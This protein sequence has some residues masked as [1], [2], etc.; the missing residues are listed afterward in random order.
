M[1]SIDVWSRKYECHVELRERVT[2]IIGDSGVGKTVFAAAVQNRANVYKIVISDTRYIITRLVGDSWYAVLR[3]DMD[4]HAYK[5]YV[6]D[7][8]DFMYT[9]EFARMYEQ[10]ENCYFI[11]ITRLELNRKTEKWN[12]IPYSAKEIYLF[13]KN[14]K[15][16]TIVPAYLYEAYDITKASDRGIELC[17]TEDSG[18]GYQFFRHIFPQV[19]AIGSKDKIISFLSHNKG[20]LQG[21]K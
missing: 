9:V 16:H 1:L 14:G 20:E 17:I 10:I 6:I 19:R 12:T 2:V 4:H 11:F 8:E 13:Q 5:V 18:S 21:K 3:N 15:K 7:D